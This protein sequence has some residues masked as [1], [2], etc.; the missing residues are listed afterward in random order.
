ML[1]LGLTNARRSKFVIYTVSLNP[2]WDYV[3]CVD[4][5]KMGMTNRTN[6]QSLIPGG[7]GINVS[8][9]LKEL[10]H[11]SIALGFTA[12]FIGK[13]L[14]REV[15]LCGI[16]TDFIHLKKGMTR[17][18]IK[19]KTETETE[20][21]G[22]GPKIDQNAVDMLFAKLD[23]L[24]QGDILVLAGSI[25]S[26]VPDNVYS[27]ILKRLD[28]RGIMF[29][30]DAQKELLLSVLKY[31]PFLTK[32]NIHELREIFGDDVKTDEDIIAAAK[33]LQQMGAQNVLVSMA[34]DGAILLDEYGRIHR[35]SAAKGRV[36]NS[37]G[38]GDS[39]VAGF[40]AGYLKHKNY[41]DALKLATAAGGAA[42]FSNGLAKRELIDEILKTL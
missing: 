4:D 16:K 23:T 9:V 14:E 34:K 19:L 7:K 40:L 27:E 11:E 28:G 24:S 37:V 8:T 38:A 35:I 36:I 33:E 3:M 2:A 20:I 29:T 5:F 26:G 12:G 21:N 30:V 25:P 18:N 31:R 39:M 42:A 13:A 17:I 10:G 22:I 6:A 41:D 32:P 1:E 15:E